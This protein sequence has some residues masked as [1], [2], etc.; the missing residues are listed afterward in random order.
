M[1][2]ANAHFKYASQDA[3]T[4]REYVP[5]LPSMLLLKTAIPVMQERQSTGKKLAAKTHWFST[6]ISEGTFDLVHNCI[7]AAVSV[8]FSTSPPAVICM[9][10]PSLIHT[11]HQTASAVLMFLLS[12]LTHVS[13]TQCL[14]HLALR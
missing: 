4:C 10:C 8:H 6:A 9:S 2:H 5:L 12:L 14:E 11:G 13:Y 1:Q 7:W 3:R